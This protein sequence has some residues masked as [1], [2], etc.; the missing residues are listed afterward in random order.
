MFNKAVIIPTGNELSQQIVIDTDSP[1]IMKWLLQHDGTIEVSRIAP[2]I[3]QEDA[4]IQA[5]QTQYET[6]QADLII[7]IGGSGE[8]HLHSTILGKDFTHASLETILTDIH[9][10]AIYGKNGHMWSK[11]LIGYYKKALVFNLPGPYEEVEVTIK[12]F[13]EA[14]AMDSHDLQAINERMVNALKNKYGA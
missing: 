11:L 14:Y 10:G 5:V 13:L 9:A 4:I 6:K 3:D 7:L 2:V 12:A 1:L 8:G